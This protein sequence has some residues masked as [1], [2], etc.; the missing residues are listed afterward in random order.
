MLYSV[1]L[2]PEEAA[3]AVEMSGSS[4]FGLEGDGQVMEGYQSASINRLRGAETRNGV[5]LVQSSVVKIY[6]K[7]RKFD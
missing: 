3:N 1:G 2:N 5:M 4:R 6:R 7:R